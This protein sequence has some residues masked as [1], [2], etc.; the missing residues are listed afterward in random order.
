MNLPKGSSLPSIPQRFEF[1]YGSFSGK[2]IFCNLGDEGD[3]IIEETNGGNFSGTPRTIHPDFKQWDLF[4]KAL[5]NC[6]IWDWEK[7]YSAAHGCCG[8]TYWHLTVDWDGCRISSRGENSF[9]GGEGQ[10]PTL[11]YTRFL[12]A[13]ELLLKDPAK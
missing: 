5:D 6:D 8:V 7:E 4:R 12:D 11:K 2:S 10:L 1:Y 13:L 3:L 9:P